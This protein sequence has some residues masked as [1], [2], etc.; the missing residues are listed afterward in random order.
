MKTNSWQKMVA[1]MIVSVAVASAVSSKAQD[2]VAPGV[3]PAAT[4]N[5][6]VPHLSYGTSQI[7]Q[8]AQAKL[9]EDT[10]IAYIRNSGN[11]YGLNA[12]QIIYLRQQ[13][14]SDAVVTAMLSQPRVGVAVATPSSPAPQPAPA[15]YA[16]QASTA[17]V[18]PS[19]S[20]VQ[21]VPDASYY[22]APYYSSYPYYGY[23][24]YYYPGYAWYPSVTVG[25]GW[26]WGWGGRGGWYHGG[27]GGGW[28]GGG[29]FHGGGGHGGGH[30]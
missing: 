29:G 24:Y 30:R 28:H 14:L 13:G 18:A 16:G 15:A 22:S 20:Y 7:L 21:A 25:W 19:A 11:S 4:V 2:L 12:D 3:S 17:T 23:P 6:S 27:Y 9:S 1:V 10:I 8:L 5:S 26:G